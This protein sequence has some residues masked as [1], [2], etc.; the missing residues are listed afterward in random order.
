M[1]VGEARR[2]GSPTLLPKPKHEGA[3]GV[4]KRRGAKVYDNT[5][6]TFIKMKTKKRDLKRKYKYGYS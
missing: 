6:N 3:R 1:R 2:A 5:T 4:K